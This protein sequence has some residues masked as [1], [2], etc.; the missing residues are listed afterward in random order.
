MRPNPTCEH[1]PTRKL[2]IMLDIERVLTLL[3]IRVSLLPDCPTR[4]H[5]L[6]KLQL[7]AR[8]PGAS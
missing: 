4:S 3:G 5:C 2:P 1:G 7:S 8:M 6:Q